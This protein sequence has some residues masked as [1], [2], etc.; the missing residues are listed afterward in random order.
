MFNT[1][2]VSTLEWVFEPIWILD[3]EC[4]LFLS[5]FYQMVATSFKICHIHSDLQKQ[6]YCTFITSGLIFFNTVN[7][8]SNRGE[9]T[10]FGLCMPFPVGAKLLLGIFIMALGV[11]QLGKEMAHVPKCGTLTYLYLS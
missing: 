10:V 2:Y 9:I 4:K 3:L 1:M 8:T 6:E 11:Q 5:I 7:I